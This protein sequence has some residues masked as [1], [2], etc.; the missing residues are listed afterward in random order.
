M[1]FLMMLGLLLK[2]LLQIVILI[3]VLYSYLTTIVVTLILLPPF[4]NKMFFY[5]AQTVLLIHLV[6]TVQISFHSTFIILLKYLFNC[7]SL[8]FA[9][10]PLLINLF[11]FYTTRKIFL[12]HYFALVILGT[13][14]VILMMELSVNEVNLMF[15]SQALTILL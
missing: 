10:H 4:L 9:P 11:D 14:H 13:S 1:V 5:R 2:L 7:L 8:L 15:N 3:L 6:L 12:G